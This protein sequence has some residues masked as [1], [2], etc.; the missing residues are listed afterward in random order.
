VRSYL[1]NEEKRAEWGI[2]QVIEPSKCETLG[3]NLRTK[4]K[5]L[6]ILTPFG[7]R[8]DPRFLQ[9]RQITCANALFSHHKLSGLRYKFV[10]YVDDFPSVLM[11][12]DLVMRFAGFGVCGCARLC[13]T[14][15]EGLEFLG[16]A[17]LTSDIW[18][19]D[20]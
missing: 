20:L 15:P 7:S 17:F 4:K 18:F 9:I 1:K 10:C 3:S 14:F 6:Y 5:K 8:R 12:W 11:L 13:Q 2:T 16:T 19:E